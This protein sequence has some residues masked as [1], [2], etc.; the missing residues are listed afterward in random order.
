MIDRKEGLADLGIG[1]RR[2]KDCMKF[3]MLMGFFLMGSTVM[4]ADYES[5]RCQIHDDSAMEKVFGKFKKMQKECCL[6]RLEAHEACESRE[7]YQKCARGGKGTFY[8]VDSGEECSPGC[9]LFREDCDD[10]ITTKDV[11][12]N[13]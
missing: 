13:L 5:I 10:F 8:A 2:E 7:D 4:A 1:P 3:L 9:K 11:N 6:K 12:T